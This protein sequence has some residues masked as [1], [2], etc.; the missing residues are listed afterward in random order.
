MKDS[1][2]PGNNSLTPAAPGASPSQAAVNFTIPIWARYLVGAI[3]VGFV[4]YS[5]FQFLR[6]RAIESASEVWATLDTLQNAEALKEFAARNDAGMA[7][8]VA[9]FKIARENL[10]N[11][12]RDF[13]S[14]K[15][16]EVKTKDNPPTTPAAPKPEAGLA[17]LEALNKAATTYGE[18]ARSGSIPLVLEIE[19]NLGAAKAL[20][21]LG[22]FSE[23]KVYYEKANSLISKSAYT[24]D[25]DLA[26]MAKTGLDRVTKDTTSV[27]ALQDQLL[28]NAKGQK[29]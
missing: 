26:K 8:K 2:Q 12:L 27:K 4:G 23:S 5:L 7:G 29:P 15:L 17:S 16:A 9:L 20:E 1:A 22:S 25:S 6:Q 3:F 13:A 18:L 24:T 28:T 19:A 21:A 11:G 14:K 10:R